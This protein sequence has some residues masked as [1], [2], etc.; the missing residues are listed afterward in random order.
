MIERFGSKRRRLSV[1]AVVSGA[2][3]L[4]AAYAYG[5]ITTTNN[6]YTGCLAGGQISSVNIGSTPTKTCPKSATQISW[7]QAGPQGLPGANGIDG[8]DGV[9]VTSTTEPAGANCADGGSKFTAANGIT[10]ACNGAKGDQGPA[11]DPGPGISSMDD[12]NGTTCAVGSTAGAVIVTTGDD[13]TIT[14]KCDTTV[15]C[16]ARPAAAA[17]STW[18]CSGG[19]W[20]LVCDA[21]W[22]DQDGD[23]ANG[24]EFLADSWSDSVDAPTVVGTLQR[25]QSASRNGTLY[26]AGD[27]DWFQVTFAAGSDISVSL[28]TNPGST[29]AFDVYQDILGIRT[30]LALNKTSWSITNGGTSAITYFIGVHSLSS[31]VIANPYVVEFVAG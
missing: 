28:T 24:C 12:L 9:S 15:N 3:V 26:P 11:G 29:F 23:P 6:Q 16:G 1:L 5:S 22:Y 14:L 21:T 25:G 8:A 30:A 18:S 2:A 31:T 20:T 13:G 7:S 17:H 4:A 19:T 27:Q 10:Y